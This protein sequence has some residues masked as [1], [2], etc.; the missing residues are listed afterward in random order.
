MWQGLAASGSRG[1][2][3]G[4]GPCKGRPGTCR[5]ARVQAPSGDAGKEG[6]VPWPGSQKATGTRRQGRGQLPAGAWEL[7][8]APCLLQDM[9]CVSWGPGQ[10]CSMLLPGGRASWHG[11]PGARLVLIV[12][13][14]I[15]GPARPL[16]LRCH[17]GFD[18][19]LHAWLE[20]A[21]AGTPLSLALGCIPEVE[22]PSHCRCVGVSLERQGVRGEQCGL[23][24]LA[25]PLWTAGSLGESPWWVREQRPDA[26]TRS[27]CL[28]CHSAAPWLGCRGDTPGAPFQTGW[29][30]AHL[31]SCWQCN[32]GQGQPW[33]RW[34]CHP[35]CS[36]SLARAARLGSRPRVSRPGHWPSARCAAP[37]NGCLPHLRTLS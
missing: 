11:C 35:C 12:C 22:A 3:P 10:G 1:P 16:E 33:Q 9:L 25:C 7:G 23:A 8:R 30:T 19:M 27:L 18:L 24:A 6:A 13:P 21:G 20:Q 29:T 36:R 26:I 15:P 28:G 17:L 14:T 5:A 34:Q 37:W 4:G 2:G 31:T 32:S